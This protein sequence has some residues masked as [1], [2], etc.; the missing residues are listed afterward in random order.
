MDD[1]VDFRVFRKDI[2]EGDLVGDVELVKGGAS[3]GD[4]LDAVDALLGGVVE[5]VN[6]DDL[7]AGLLKSY[8]GVGAN[9]A[10]ATA[11]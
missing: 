9:V 5:V 4:E 3:A 1:A 6:N 11:A 2:V 10:A 7:V 8:N